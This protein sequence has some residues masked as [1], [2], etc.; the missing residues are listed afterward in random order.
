MVNVAVYMPGGSPEGSACTTSVEGC[1]PRSAP[2]ATPWARETLSQDAEVDMRQARGPVPALEMTNE[3]GMLIT[4]G[5]VT[6]VIWPVETLNV[7]VPMTELRL[8]LAV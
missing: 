4:G 1:E 2:T 6:R 8:P 5:T 3:P 7:G